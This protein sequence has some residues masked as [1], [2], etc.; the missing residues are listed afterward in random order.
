M[1]DFKIGNEEATLRLTDLLDNL[2]PL[3]ADAA[4]HG[5]QR[6]SGQFR[7]GQKR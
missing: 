2:A 7:K 6:S 3:S 5:H 1:L 4:R